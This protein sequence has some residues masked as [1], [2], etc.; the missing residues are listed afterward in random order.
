MVERRH[1]RRGNT[2]VAQRGATA[3]DAD[4]CKRAVAPHPFVSSLRGAGRTSIRIEFTELW[5]L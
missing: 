5:G 2:M 3:E 4:T 1:A